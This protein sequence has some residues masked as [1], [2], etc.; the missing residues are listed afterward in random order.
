MRAIRFLTYVKR[1]SVLASFFCFV[2]PAFSGQIQL[3]HVVIDKDAIGHREVGDIDGDGFNDIAAVN[4]AKSEHFIV[5]YKY[6]NWSK[7][8]IADI[9]EFSDYKA[10]R[11]CD[12]EL[13]DIDGDGD[14]DLVGRIGRP[15]DDKYGIN[16]WFENPKPSGNP[17]GNN[18]KRHDIGE[19]YYAK[20]L[21]VADL[22]GDGKL[23]VISRAL[24]AKLHI[25][26]QE[27]SSWKER[28]LEI[29]HHDGMDVGDMDR[30]GDPD[31]VLNGYWIETPDDPLTGSWVKHDFDNKWYTQKTGEKGRWYD[32]NCKVIVADMNRDSCLDI[33]IAHAEDKGYPVSW[34]QAP[35]DPKNGKWTEHVIAQV[36]KCHSLKVADFDNDGDLDVLVG[37]MPNIPKEAPHPVLVFIN[38]GNALKWKQ[39]LL[40]NRGNYSAQVGDIDNDGDIDIIGLR[41]HN[42][43]PIEMWRNKTSDNKLSLDDWTYIEVDNKRGK[44][45][46]WDEPNWLKYFGL[47]MADVTGDGYKDIIAGRY[48]YRNPGGNMSGR[49][50]RITFSINVDAMLVVDVDG[51]S[52]ADIIAEALPNVYWLEAEDRPGNSWSVKKI[53]TLPKT[54]HVNG[55]GY[56]LGQII[57]GGKPE[58]IL[59]CGDGIYYFQIP[60]NPEN[61]NWPKTR[62]ASETMDEGI[63]TGDIDGDGDIDITTGKKERETFMVIWHENPGNGSA[64]WK[65]HLVSQT[66]FAPDRIV[67]AEVNGDSRLDIVVSEE[68]Y[69]GPDPDAS[70]YW[71]EQPSYPKSQTW[72]KHIVITEYSLNNL[73]LADMDRDGDFDVITCEHKGPK[74]KFRLQIFENDGKGNF[75]EHIADRGK[76]SHLGAKVADM[77]NDGDLDIVSAAW[78]NY[79]FLHLWRNDN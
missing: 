28:V 10:Y 17:A 46:D 24:N 58:I 5:W 41:N 57:A 25:Y 4:T 32:N 55:Q 45:G 50:Q 40:T 6:P 31:I 69:P 1:I 72:K 3:E 30:D 33:V 47:A 75:T 29:T 63:G 23:D 62:I 20:D 13:A 59:A 12:M 43:A 61:G 22:N 79:Q 64:D 9:S 74:G 56:M 38:Q 34:Y 27:A 78:D 39:Q 42:S 52:F 7:Y 11:S 73:D 8:T 15:E 77:D 68:R 51:D 18:W 35:A 53:G 60:G 49:W 44:W 71:F 54:G 70:L 65:G 37:E 76:E 66:A 19:N 21:E 48:F 14:L 2:L 26:F 36:D 16:C 67:I